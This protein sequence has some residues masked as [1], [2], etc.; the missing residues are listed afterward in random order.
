MTIPFSAQ[1]IRDVVPADQDY[2]WPHRLSRMRLDTPRCVCDA[3]K[4]MAMGRV[5]NAPAY[6]ACEPYARYLESRT[7][8]FIF[9]FYMFILI[10]GT[11]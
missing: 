11:H 1:Y 5:C 6:R 10:Q 7:F 2:G 4:S 9:C 3:P 8:S